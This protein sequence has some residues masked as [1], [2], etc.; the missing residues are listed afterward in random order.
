VH[1]RGD[2]PAAGSLPQ[3]GDGLLRPGL[4]VAVALVP[5]VDDD[6]PDAVVASE[7]S[8][9]HFGEAH[10]LAIDKDG[11]GNPGVVWGSPCGTARATASMPAE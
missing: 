6:A 7:A 3:A 5:R 10:A 1:R 2:D 4:G 9:A 11:D 8:F